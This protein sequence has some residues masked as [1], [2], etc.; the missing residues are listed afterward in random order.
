MTTQTNFHKPKAI[1]CDDLTCSTSTFCVLA[2]TDHQ[3]SGVNI[4]L[5]KENFDLLLQTVNTFDR[6][7]TV[8]KAA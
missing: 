8:E 2:L 4:F 1:T 5:T 7:Q 6:M 3:G